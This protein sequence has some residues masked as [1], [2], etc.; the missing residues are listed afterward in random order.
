MIG[1]QERRGLAGAFS[2]AFVPPCN[3]EGGRRLSDQPP[4]P[5]DGPEP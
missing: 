2:R 3:L 5:V 4:V 1:V